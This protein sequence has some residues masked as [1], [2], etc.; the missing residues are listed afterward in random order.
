[1]GTD[2]INNTDF[3]ELIKAY[4]KNPEDEEL[5]HELTV[6]F[7]LLADNIIKAFNFKLIDREDALQEGVMAA[8]TKID[9]FKPERGGAFSWLTTIMLNHFR[10]LYRSCKNEIS[11]KER[12]KEEVMLR[13]RDTATFTD[14]D[15]DEM[16][17]ITNRVRRNSR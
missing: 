14:T 6:C 11:L 3:E 16:Q 5:K 1:M 7:Y 2:Y 15:N 10:Q 9:R 4:L 13:S 12:Y 17:E 8:L